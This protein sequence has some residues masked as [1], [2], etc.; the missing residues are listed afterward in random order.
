MIALDGATGEYLWNTEIA[1]GTNGPGPTIANDVVFIGTL[2]GI[3]RGYNIADGS[4][5]WRSQTSAG[6]NAPFA[7]AGDMLLVPGGSFIAASSDSPDPLPGVNTTV[8]AYKLGATG[9]VALAE[10]GATPEAA[11]ED[12]DTLKHVSAV[13]LAFEPSELTIS[14]DTEVTIAVTNHGNLQHDLVIEGTDFATEMLAGGGS[15]EIVVNL[16]AGTY[17]Y[18]CSVSGHRESGMQGTLTVE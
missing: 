13:D 12:S 15:G 6:L 9:E 4:E 5:V 2:D 1:S 10:P 11:G 18:Y 8:I 7:V 17:A 3:A 16:P 14:A